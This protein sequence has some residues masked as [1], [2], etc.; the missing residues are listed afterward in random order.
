MILSREMED[1]MSSAAC[2]PLAITILELGRAMK[3]LHKEGLQLIILSYEMEDIM[4]FAACF[5]LAMS[6]LL[7][8]R[9]MKHV[10]K[11]SATD[12]TVL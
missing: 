9:A 12:H 10:N 11:R 7:F 6:I 2:L 1:I 8:E 5:P 3:H 4:F